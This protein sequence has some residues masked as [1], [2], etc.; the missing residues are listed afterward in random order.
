VTFVPG[1]FSLSWNLFALGGADKGK[2]G[3]DGG[4]DKGKGGSDGGA[5]KGKGK[6]KGK[7]KK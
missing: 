3:S 6:G 5:D 4:S 7:G 2:G 1:T